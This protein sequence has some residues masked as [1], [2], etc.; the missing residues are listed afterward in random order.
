MTFSIKSAHLNFFFLVVAVAFVLLKGATG[1]DFDVFLEA[2]QRLYNHENI[3]SSFSSGGF[4][5]YYSPFFALILIPFSH[6]IVLTEE[7]WLLLSLMLLYRSFKIIELNFN[8]ADYSLKK[9]KLWVWLCFI[10]SVQFILNNI[11]LIQVTML[12][13]WGILE[14]LHQ[15]KKNKSLLAG[16]ILG[17]V[18]VIKLMPLLML[19]YL[20][21]R[22]QFRMLG[23]TL[24]TFVALLILPSIF[25]GF[26]YNFFLLKNWF[27]LIN[28]NNSELVVEVPLGFH[29]LAGLFSVYLM[30][31]HGELPYKQ[32]FVSWNFATVNALVDVA[33]VGLLVLS[34]YFFQSK[35]FSK[36][37]NTLKTFWEI[38]YF[39]FI[40]PL[41]MPHQNKYGF[42]LCC[43]MVC[44]LLYF[45]ILTFKK[46]HSQS[47]I[48]IFIIF[49]IAIVVYS[50]LNGSDILGWKLYRI[51]QHFRLLSFATLMLIPVAMYCSPKKFYE[52][53]SSN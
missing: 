31:T 15:N 35:P 18:C 6:F 53:N 40:I 14:S 49:A 30:P 19:P 47:Y 11:T 33:R 1:G 20:F 9:K 45:Y 16:F 46:A 28:P 36:E 17:F 43:P 4:Q 44:Y 13:L 22:G 3:Y 39:C 51:G 42:L 26:D 24:I 10:F 50:P 7:A 41:I 34:L 29:D 37:N 23:Y 27:V 2:A 21:Y 25:I 8:F 32:N 12:L 38:A 52:I 48:F 5:W